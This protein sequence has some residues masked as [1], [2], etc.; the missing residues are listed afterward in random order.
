LRSNP[1]AENPSV[2]YRDAF[3]KACEDYNN[4]GAAMSNRKLQIDTNM[5]LKLY[6]LKVPNFEQSSFVG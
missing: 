2:Q 4:Y 3:L 6:G 1:Q 5:A